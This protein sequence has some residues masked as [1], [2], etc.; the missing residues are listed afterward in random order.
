MIKDSDGL[1]PSDLF[2]FNI[3]SNN[4]IVRD[5]N[6]NTTIDSKL[7]S[8]IAVAS[9]SPDSIDSLD[10]V[11]FA[12]FNRNIKH[13]FFKEK[14]VDEAKIEDIKN[15]KILKYNRD[16]EELQNMLGF[17]Y[18]YKIDILKGNFKDNDK[19][20]LQTSTARRYIKI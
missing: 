17:L 10:A 1:Q 14:E 13:R 15:K 18:D 8:T 20:N 16:I 3:H 4:S 2:E 11:S 9:Q 12:A 7:S 19:N 5:F 6:Y